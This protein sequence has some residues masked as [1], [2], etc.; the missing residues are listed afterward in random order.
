VLTYIAKSDAGG[1][2]DDGSAAA[3]AATCE[4][5]DWKLVEIVRDREVGPSLERPALGYALKQIANGRAEGLVVSNLQ[6][7]SRS[8][9]NLD[10]LMAWFRDAQAALI[11]IRLE[12]RHVHPQRST[13][14]QQAHRTE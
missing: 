9:V 14:R 1:G 11:R 6:R 4:R 8:I 3:I 13:R 2:E 5:F 10:A 12:Q 7:L